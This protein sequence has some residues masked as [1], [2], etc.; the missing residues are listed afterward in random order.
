MLVVRREGAAPMRARVA[1]Q[2]ASGPGK[3]NGVLMEAMQ[4][5]RG[6]GHATGRVEGHETGRAEGH[7]A[8]AAE[9]IV[10]LVARPIPVSE[11]ERERILGMR[12]E[13]TLARWLGAVATCT[14]ADELLRS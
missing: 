7:A 10:V 11:A 9:A 13:A 12:S 1:R 4:R 6:E 5:E 14:S 2:G 8:G 3:H